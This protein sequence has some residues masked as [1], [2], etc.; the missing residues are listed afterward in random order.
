MSI[1][2]YVGCGRPV[3]A[4]GMCSTHYMQQRR[5]G[6]IP[7]GTRK[8]APVT[9]RFWRQ[10]VKTETCWLWTGGKK[11]KAG[12]GQIGMGGK[13][14]PQQLAHRFSYELHNGPITDGRLV[15][16]SCDNPRCVNPDHLSLGTYS[17]N[18]Q[19]AVQKG[20]WKSIPPLHCGEW[21]HNSKL[22]ADDVRL[23]R[24]NQDISSK[25]LAMR[26]GVNLSSIQKVRSRKTWKHIP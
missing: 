1:C 25:E 11:S 16:H 26:F 8:Q 2:S 22:T 17:E 10:V 18:T 3:D 7:T 13:G 9:E 15:M 6:L 20:R 21:Q 24:D 4:R 5:A 12:Y 14:A 23:I 19:D